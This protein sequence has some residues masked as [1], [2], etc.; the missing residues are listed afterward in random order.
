MTNKILFAP[1][2]L[3]NWVSKKKLDEFV[4]MYELR[5]PKS[6]DDVNKA[7]LVLQVGNYI[8]SFTVWGAGTTE[9]L[10]LDSNSNNVITSRDEEFSNAS[11]LFLKIDA[12]FNEIVNL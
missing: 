1:E 5:L 8:G 3:A 12:A 11:Q 6:S 9:W 4:D 7:V 2:A 10:V